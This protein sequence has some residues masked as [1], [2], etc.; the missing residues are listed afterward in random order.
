MSRSNYYKCLVKGDTLIPFDE[1]NEQARNLIIKDLKVD[2]PVWVTVLNNKPTRSQLQNNFYWLYLS[3]F[4][5]DKDYLHEYFK[6]KFAPEKEIEVNGEIKRVKKTTTTMT[7]QEFST[8]IKNI[9]L[10]TGVLAP[11]NYSLL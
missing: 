2:E 3:S 10:E 8:Y 6:E 5:E 9:E 11:L 1:T 7:T 4:E